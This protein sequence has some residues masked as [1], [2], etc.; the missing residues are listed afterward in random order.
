MSTLWPCRGRRR[1]PVRPGGATWPA[2]PRHATRPAE[3]KPIGREGRGY[4]WLAALFSQRKNRSRETE[5]RLR[6]RSSRVPARPARP[7]S[8]R[9]WPRA[10][11][12]TRKGRPAM[13][14][15]APAGCGIRDLGP[16][17]RVKTGREP[18]LHLSP[19]MIASRRT[20]CRRRSSAMNPVGGSCSDAGRPR[21]VGRY[22]A[23]RLCI[24]RGFDYGK[25]NRKA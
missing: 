14:S 7:G 6:R 4:K 16:V 9:P 10:R 22:G 12:R 3:E 21:P 19:H 18:I 20:E 15:L 17:G 1:R 11:W 24:A 25:D 2:R 5:I 8:L 13:E 23:M